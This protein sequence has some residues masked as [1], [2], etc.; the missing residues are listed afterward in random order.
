MKKL[1]RPSSSFVKQHRQLLL[2]E[3]YSTMPQKLFRQRNAPLKLNAP[4]QRNELRQRRWKILVILIL[5]AIDAYIIWS[6]GMRA[7]SERYP[8]LV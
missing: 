4:R 1:I 8:T 2:N 5:L 3:V 7:L 6:Q